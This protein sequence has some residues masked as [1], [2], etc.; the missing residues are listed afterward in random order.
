MVVVVVVVVVV[1][2]VLVTSDLVPKLADFGESREQIST[3]MTSVGTHYW[4]APEVYN[5]ERYTERADV[6]S[7]AVVLMEIFYHADLAAIFPDVRHPNRPLP[8]TQVAGQVLEG[9]RPEI[10]SHVPPEAARLISQCW[11]DDDLDR[12]PFIEIL[13]RLKRMRRT[14][15]G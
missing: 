8:G 12:P 9:W 13:D 4:V 3:T 5:G 10:G 15:C 6:Y 2:A 11:M 1:D 14:M 7:F